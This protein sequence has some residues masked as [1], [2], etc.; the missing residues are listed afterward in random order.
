[1]WVIG[2]CLHLAVAEWRNKRIEEFADSGPLF[3]EVFIPGFQASTYANMLST[4][5]NTKHCS[6]PVN[7]NTRV[8][9]CGSSIMIWSSEKNTDGKFN[10]SC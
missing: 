9:H 5:E 4:M 6:S 1:M 8:R 2:V 7:V 10:R 3:S